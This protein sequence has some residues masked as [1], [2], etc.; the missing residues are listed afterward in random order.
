MVLDSAV[1]KQSKQQANLME[2]PG[3]TETQ[4]ITNRMHS[5]AYTIQKEEKKQKR[6]L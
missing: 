6:G 5:L 2:S 3:N 1:Q 4:I